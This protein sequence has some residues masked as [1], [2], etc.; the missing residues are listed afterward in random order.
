MQGENTAPS[1][2]IQSFSFKVEI[3]LLSGFRRKNKR[4]NEKK[5]LGPKAQLQPCDLDGGRLDHMT[6]HQACVCE[7]GVGE[8]VPGSKKA[9]LEMDAS[10]YIRA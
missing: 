10:V 3:I 7:V 6:P 1:T 8:G 2:F 4:W 5:S 9:L